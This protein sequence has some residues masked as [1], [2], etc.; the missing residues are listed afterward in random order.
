[1]IEFAIRTKTAMIHFGDYDESF[2]VKTLI[3]DNIM[4]VVS[5][6]GDLWVERHPF[7]GR[8]Y[9]FD[10]SIIQEE[11]DDAIKNREDKLTKDA[12]EVLTSNPIE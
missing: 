8:E 3:D 10:F 4:C 12:A 5:E 11:I 7:A 6:D 2:N 9:D 1:M